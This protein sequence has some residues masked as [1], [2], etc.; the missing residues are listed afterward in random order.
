MKSEFKRVGSRNP[1]VLLHFFKSAKSTDIMKVLT[2]EIRIIDRY[3]VFRQLQKHCHLKRRKQR[4]KIA[5]ITGACGTIFDSYFNTQS[6]SVSCFVFSQGGG[7][8]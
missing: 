5:V 6:K 3:T 1:A 2:L 7:G 4:M 8:L